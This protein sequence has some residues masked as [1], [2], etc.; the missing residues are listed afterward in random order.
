MMFLLSV[1]I[2]YFFKQS[3]LITSAKKKGKFHSKNIVSSS[4]LNSND[5]LFLK[6][7]DLNVTFINKITLEAYKN[8]K[9]SA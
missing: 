3:N 1:Q 2:L 6:Y 5:D 4:N 7:M 9:V 8:Q